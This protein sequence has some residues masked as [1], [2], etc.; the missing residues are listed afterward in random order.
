MSRPGSN[1]RWQCMDAHL[2]MQ[3]GGNL[4][5]TAERVLPH[6]VLQLQ[7]L[8]LGGHHDAR[9]AHHNVRVG[10]RIDSSRDRRHKGLPLLDITY[11]TH[12]EDVQA[13]NE[14]HKVVL[15]SSI[16]GQEWKFRVEN[17]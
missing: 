4:E 15:L 7:L 14:E 17:V 10:H 13:L 1:T 16:T 2:R 9:R 3:I 8:L 5:S 11:R 12:K 6:F